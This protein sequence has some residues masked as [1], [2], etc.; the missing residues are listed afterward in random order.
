MAAIKVVLFCGGT[1]ARL[2]DFSENVPK[3]MVH[4]GYRPILW[5]VMKYYASFGH[6]DFILCLGYRADVIKEYFL[7]YNEAVS[8]DFVLS[9]EGQVELLG[10]DIH[11]W[12][13]SFVDSGVTSSVGER[14]RAVQPY[15]ADDE[16]FL[17]NYTD[18]LTDLDLSRYIA[19]VVDRGTIANFVSVR[20][21][22]TFHVVDAGEEGIVSRIDPVSEADVRINAG[23]YVFRQE[24]FEFLREGE[25]L[26]GPPFDRLIARKELFAHK[27]DGF[28]MGMDT[29]KEKEQLE[30]MWA[31]GKPPWVVW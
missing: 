31:S 23:W 7:R 5:H 2:R 14:L 22:L 18:G 10:S 26:V 4:I 25:D 29:F 19:E 20:P 15:V 24:I 13:I 16:V 12:R 17:A 1:G 3:P 28:W 27:Y 6:K 9:G 8:N 30:D 21:S 11:D